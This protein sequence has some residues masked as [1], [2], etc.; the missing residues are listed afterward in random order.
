ME[1]FISIL[2]GLLILAGLVGIIVPL[3]PGI[4][5]VF[6]GTLIF[7]WTGGFEEISLWVI[8]IF[9][10]LTLIGTLFDY[11][12][13]IYGAKKF[14][15]SWWGAL[16]AFLGLILGIAFFGPIGLII[17]PFLG[18]IILELASKKQLKTAL[19]AG[20][21]TL[22]MYLITTTYNFSLGLIMAI[23]FVRGLY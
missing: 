5:L 22:I 6:L 7:A 9:L 18:V 16:G 10:V 20:I 4:P 19:K 2:S 13:G 15:A 8:I 17:G 1:I 14:G 12:G 23:F 11:F 21:G 3:F